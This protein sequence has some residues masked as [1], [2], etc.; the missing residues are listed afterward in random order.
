MNMSKTKKR[1]IVIGAGP[2]GLSSAMILAHRGFDVVVYEKQG[3]VGGR[4][5]AF[6]VGDFIFELGPTFVMLP[7]E[8][9]EVFS[10]AGRKLSD[11]L[12]MKLLDTMYRL[13][14]GDGRNFI[15]SYDKEKMKREIARVFP[16]DEVGYELYLKEQKRKFEL[17]Y[18][19]LKV[20][21]IR[22]YHYL[23]PK[24]L[25]A[26]P[27]MQNFSSLYD[28]MAKYFVHDDMRISMTFQAK[29]LGMSPWHC[30]GAFSII[31]YIEHAFGIFH[32]IGGV[33]KI[34]EMMAKI[35]EEEKGRVVLNKPITKILIEDG[36]AVGVIFAD[37]S[38][39]R[40]DY[41]IM[42]ADFAAGMT[43]L[44]PEDNRGKWTDKELKKR[45]YSCS[46]FMLYLGLD[47]KY[48]FPHHNVFFANDYKKNIE[49]IFDGKELSQD[50]SFYIQNASV[51]DP[52]LAPEGKSTIYILVP[53]PNLDAPIDWDNKKKY[54]RDLVIKKISEKTEMPDIEKHIEVERVITPKDWEQKIDVYKGAVFNLSHTIGQM[55]YLRPHNK[56]E[57]LPGLFLVGGGTHPGSGLP[58]I[59]ESGRIAADLISEDR[60]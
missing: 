34:T 47:K 11:Y 4:T 18:P 2:G 12:D 3:Y 32:T 39:D 50:P 23:R 52:T 1:V 55:L 20:P 24:L 13:Q 56:F 31:S 53:V 58:T 60:I 30:P 49:Q 26:F 14:F 28:V 36:K 5:S 21:Y 10:K 19:C 46:T 42:N 22:W 35:V 29:Y 54:Y 15:V 33:H 9:E 38:T 17:M 25:K 37:G 59:I 48:D 8:F 51:T 27:Y 43:K 45:P 40:A 7:Q 6:Q 16:G 44:V 41:V 57:E